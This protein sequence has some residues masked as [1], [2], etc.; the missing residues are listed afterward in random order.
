VVEGGAIEAIN[1]TLLESMPLLAVVA[2][3]PALLASR[4]RTLGASIRAWLETPASTADLLVLAYGFLLTT[5][6]IPRLPIHAQ[7]TVRYLLALYPLLLYAGIR[8]PAVSKAIDA[9]F[10]TVV[11]TWTATV[12]IGTQLLYTYISLTALELG[13]ALQLHALLGL[14]VALPLGV[15]SVVA[16]LRGPRANSSIGGLTIGFAAGTG[17]VFLLLTGLA[18]FSYTGDFALPIADVVSDALSFGT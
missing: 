12:F 10:A 14:V 8:L 17:T 5:V 6:Y 7:V 15:W 9:S 18:Y 11:W 3:I 16:T 4:W 1:L 2:G 13:E